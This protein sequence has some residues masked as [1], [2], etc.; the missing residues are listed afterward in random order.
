MWCVV[1]VCVTV[2]DPWSPLVP[3][4]TTHR[5]KGTTVHCENFSSGPAGKREAVSGLGPPE[6]ARRTLDLKTPSTSGFGSERLEHVLQTRVPRTYRVPPRPTGPWWSSLARVVRRIFVI[7]GRRGPPLEEL[8]RL[9][10]SGS[11]K[12][13]QRKFHRKFPLGLS[14]AF[15]D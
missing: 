10:C 3:R 9:S 8:P 1:Y 14:R 6:G 7:F 13:T 11:V 5:L 12:T 2:S 4:W 15:V